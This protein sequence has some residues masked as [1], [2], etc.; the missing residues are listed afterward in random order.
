MQLN[1]AGAMKIRPELRI[2]M[3]YAISSG[4][5]ATECHLVG[6]KTQFDV[7]NSQFDEKLSI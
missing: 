5:I 7:G 4:K 6:K 3:N 2:A 1:E